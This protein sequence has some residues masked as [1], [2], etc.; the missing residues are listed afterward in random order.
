MKNLFLS[1]LL[2][3]TPVFAQAPTAPLITSVANAT[4]NTVSVTITEADPG[5][6]IHVTIDG[7]TPTAA[8]PLYVTPLVLTKSAT[9]QA[10]AVVIPAT[11]VSSQT[12]TIIPQPT[13]FPFTLGARPASLSFT[14]Q[15]GAASSTAQSLIVWDSSP[16]PA[17]PPVPMCNWPVTASTDVPWLTASSGTTGFSSTVALNTSKLTTAGTF[18]G[19]V[20]L[21]QAQFNT[22]T[23]KIP[24]TVIVTP[25]AV[26]HS[27]TLS[28]TASV[29]PTVTG[30]SVLR[31]TASGGPY[32]SMGKV[33]TLAYLDAAVQGGSTYFYVLTAFDAAGDVSPNST[34]VTAVIP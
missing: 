27:V 17:V 9:V 26:A 24:V 21:T 8:S 25:A 7:S 33:A 29:S 1:F 5:Y 28:W 30:Y 13:T 10:I 6:E 31:G 4:T 22:P 18:T 2:F 11:A 15:L 19:N 3:S 16:C 23:L 20:I 32:T 12:F 14:Y 34:E